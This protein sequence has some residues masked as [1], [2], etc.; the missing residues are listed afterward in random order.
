MLR[1]LPYRI[2]AVGK[3]RKAW[4][5][6]G[7]EI[8]LKRMPGLGIVEIKD[9]NPKKEAQLINQKLNINERLIV[10]SEEGKKMSS[11]DFSNYLMRVGSQR[12]L[13]ALGGPN[14]F[15]PKIKDEA[16]S[17]LS[18]SSMTFTHEIARLILLEQ[19][20]RAQTITDGS[21]YHRE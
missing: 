3:I 10:I 13:F 8:Y 1:K 4:I 5:Q 9:S 6:E 21:P 12:I 16:Y 19:I 20:Y 7:I 18:L 11:L 2:L 15:D 14:G 17:T